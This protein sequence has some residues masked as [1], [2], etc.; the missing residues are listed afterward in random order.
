MA[1]VLTVEA[2]PQLVGAKGR[3]RFNG[4]AGTCD[5]MLGRLISTGKTE[6]KL[7]G[8]PKASRNYAEPI[9]SFWTAII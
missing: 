6:A 7:G 3:R 5:P 2:S 9:L 8:M 4:T 1:D